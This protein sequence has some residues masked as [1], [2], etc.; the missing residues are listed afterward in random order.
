VTYFRRERNMRIYISDAFSCML[1]RH[2]LF[3]IYDH[4]L[5]TN[6]EGSMEVRAEALWVTF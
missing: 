1:Q 2:Q 5:A 6:S 3:W 4:H